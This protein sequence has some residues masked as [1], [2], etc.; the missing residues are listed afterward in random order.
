MSELCS[1]GL[2]YF[3][4]L[5]VF[6]GFL[7]GQDWKRE[8]CRDCF[9]VVFFFPPP[10]SE[11]FAKPQSL[12]YQ[13]WATSSPESMQ[14]WSLHCKHI[15]KTLGQLIKIMILKRKIV[16]ETKQIQP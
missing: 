6:V 4:L 12:D 3:R 7:S 10:M 9:S 5:S 16:V 13:A 8:G 1:K 15:I 14:D 11:V 2:N